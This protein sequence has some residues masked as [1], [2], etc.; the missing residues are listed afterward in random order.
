[1]TKIE[2]LIV[3]PH[4]DDE[5]LGCGGWLITHQSSCRVLVL[6]TKADVD[7]EDRLNY[8]WELGARYHFQVSAHSFPVTRF[9]DHEHEIRMLIHQELLAHPQAKR[10]FLPSAKD[11]H[12]DH[13]TVAEA[14][15]YAVRSYAYPR[16]CYAPTLQALTY[17]VPGS[18]ENF[19]PTAFLPVT[20]DQVAAK[21]AAMDGY[22]EQRRE[23]PHPRSS[24]GIRAQMQGFG[25]QI[26]T[27]Y[28]E[29]YEIQWEV[30]S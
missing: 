13:Q 5:I 6:S 15:R 24:F 30:L 12:Q 10:V 28:A 19:R 16:N 17:A 29:A 3:A 18:T 21:I 2:T 26:G 14:A 23:S 25:V 9:R 22:S 11:M 27:E 1:M 8:L 7:Q 20:A 4:A